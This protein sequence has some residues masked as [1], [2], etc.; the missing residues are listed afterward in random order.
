MK[1]KLAYGK[2]GLEWNVPDGYH[3]DIIEPQW[4]DG[5]K[6]QMG[7]VTQ[8]LKS[9]IDSKPLKDLVSK[10]TKIGIIFS[11]ITRATPYHIILPALLKELDHIDPQ[12]IILFCATGTHRPAP[13]AELETILGKNI[14]SSYR[15]VQ[16]DTNDK[17]QY[18]HAGNTSSGNEIYLNAELAACDL[19]ILTGF[20][21]P[22][23]FM[24][25]S[26][27]GKA[28]MPGMGY[29]DTIRYNHSISMLENENAR[30]GITTGNP[31][32]EDV[33]EAAELLPD[34]FL[35]NITLNK[36]KEITGVFAGDLKSA[37]QKGCAF[38]KDTAMAPVDKPFD[39]VITSNSGYPLDLNI[40]QSVKGMSAAMQVVKKGGD[41]LIAA[42]CWDGIPANTDYA[43]ILASAESIDELYDYIK[44]NE[45]DLQDTWQ[46]FFQVIIQQWANVS[47]YTDK[48]D[49]ETVR[50]A[51]FSPVRNPEALIRDILIK[52]GPAARICVLP[53]GP[54][55][56]PYLRN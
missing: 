52:H 37:H 8:A 2:M 27:G 25:F 47:L 53:E 28:V 31:L 48:L 19:K 24:G 18:M 12:N 36:Q 5:L 40:Y 15:I 1:I 33:Q 51:L 6:D 16:N 17:S 41:I 46:V 22:H 56:I 13:P 29:L 34:L 44:K 23:F 50:K 43:R 3:V 32:W 9:P 11:D 42:E 20:I 38:A 55:T 49:D 7:A 10:D 21:E 14:A 4:V 30:W 39:L 35:L 45:K 26:G 54:Q